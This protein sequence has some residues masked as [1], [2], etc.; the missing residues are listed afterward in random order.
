MALSWRWQSGYGRP[1]GGR[2]VA[3]VGGALSSRSLCRGYHERPPV[4]PHQSGEGT[5]WGVHLSP[6]W[7]LLSGAY[8][9]LSITGVASRRLRAGAT[10]PCYLGHFDLGMAPVL[11]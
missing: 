6:A 2:R 5:T 3:V 11:C 7:A 8:W 4:A 9:E 1:L 10:P